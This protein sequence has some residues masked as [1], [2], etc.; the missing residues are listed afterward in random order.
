MHF[1]QGHIIFILG[2]PFK[3]KRDAIL[4]WRVGFSNYEMTFLSKRW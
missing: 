1:T 3:L 4:D 2:G